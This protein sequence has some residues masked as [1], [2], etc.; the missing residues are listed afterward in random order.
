MQ[1]L[2]YYYCQ[3]FDGSPLIIIIVDTNA[4]KI[5]IYAQMSFHTRLREIEEGVTSQFGLERLSATATQVDH[6]LVR[7]IDR[8]NGLVTLKIVS[9]NNWTDL[10]SYVEKKITFLI[11]EWRRTAT[12]TSV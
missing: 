1:D 8:V 4:A 2:K 5:E 11:K 6:C 12:L 3:T 7:S 10:W 9:N